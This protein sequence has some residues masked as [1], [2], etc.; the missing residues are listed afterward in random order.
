VT[1]GR[2]PSDS[3]DG[4][5]ASGHAWTAETTPR[6]RVRDVVG[7][8]YEPVSV[9][10]VAEEARTSLET[11]R[12][13]LEALAEEGYVTAEGG[14]ERGYRR[15]PESL[16]IEQVADIRAELSRAELA[17]R[18][19]ELRE[20]VASFREE[21]GVESPEKLTAVG[22]TGAQNTEDREGADPE[23]IR[24]WQRI[25]RNLAFASAALSVST[26]ERVVDDRGDSSDGTSLR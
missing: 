17:T 20:D 11:A 23:T 3:G 22:G 2:T 4:T 26:A 12:N 8:A 25:R 24:E 14:S 19:A 10:T 1:D 7:Y 6:E 21:Y 9:S 13:Q 5:E 16:V 18:L 15:S